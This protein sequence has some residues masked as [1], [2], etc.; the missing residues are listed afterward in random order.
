METTRIIGG[1]AFVAAFFAAAC[2]CMWLANALTHSRTLSEAALLSGAESSR[3]HYLLRNGIRPFEP[4]ARALVKVPAIERF[5]GNIRTTLAERGVTTYTTSL[6]SLMVGISIILF[7]G[8][9]L[10]SGSWVFAITAIFLAII[11]LNTWVTKQQ[12]LYKT[13]LREEL[14]AALQGMN[15]C[16]CVGYSLPQIFD[17][18]AL[19]LEGPLKQVF[20]RTAAVINA[21]GTVEEAL[22]VL[23][24]Q[25]NEPELFFLATALEIQHRT[26][27]SLS[28]VLEVV[29]Q[30]V[31]DQLELKRLLQTQTAQAKLS[32][33]IVTIMPFV[34]IGIFSLISEGFLDPFFTSTIGIL[35]LCAA[36]AMQAIGIVLVRKILHVEV[37]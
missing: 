18:V 11:A 24:H 2:L 33:Q 5:L 28:Q 22:E 7:A 17:Q 35:L 1:I 8:G 29:R 14:P 31:S 10:L 16:F 12:E 30:S 20:L 9:M 19:D 21:G 13:R 25:T 27:S 6:A 32:A 37:A 23:K 26:G 4:L 36:I 15:A 34:L 3:M